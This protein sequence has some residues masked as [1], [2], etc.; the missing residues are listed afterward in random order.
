[1]KQNLIK[2][3]LFL[4]LGAAVLGAL[5]LLAGE[6]QQP[7]ATEPGATEASGQE[8]QSTTPS[9][10]ALPTEETAPVLE[11]N[12]FAPADFV[13]DGEWMT[14]SKKP[15]QL[16][17]DVSK[18]QGNIDW[19][20]VAAAGIRFAILRVGGRGY[21]QSGNLFA[22]ETAQKNYTAAKAAGLQVGAY[23]FSQ[24][25]S[26]EE[27]REEAAY[28]LEL[29]KDWSLEL[30]IAFDWEY[31]SDTARTANTD[32]ATVTACAQ[33]FC[34]ELLAAG[35]QAMVYIRPEMQILKL[36]ALAEYP[37]WVALYSDTMD[38]PYRFTLWQYSKTG[39]VPG[40]AGNVDLNIWIP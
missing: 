38:H 39:K 20:R 13:R 8:T 22:D 16:G 2:L 24:A 40:I 29:V 37:H 25:V 34:E 30:P 31:V 6:L 26:V 1:M 15:C 28:V 7:D 3:I 36:E 18:Y 11:K 32:A 21:G 35:R 5:L 23:F 10:S 9:E 17:V 19:E 33:A 12:P 4:C 14:C 27:A